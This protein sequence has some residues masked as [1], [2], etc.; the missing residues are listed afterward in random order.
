LHLQGPTQRKKHRTPG[1]SSIHGLII[2][3]GNVGEELGSYSAGDVFLS[4]DGGF[5]WE[6]IHKEPHIWEFGNSGSLLV[7]A[8][9]GRPTNHV[10]FSTDLGLTWAK[11]QFA[12]GE[13]LI[14]D[15]ITNP[16]GTSRRFIVLGKH[17]LHPSK[18]FAIK[19]DFSSLITRECMSLPAQDYTA[20]LTFNN[21]T[22]NSDRDFEFWSP[23]NHG[24]N[25]ILGKQVRL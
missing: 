2:G 25:C 1:A 13:L 11:H 21:I 8:H 16:S 23:Y 6:E 12:E 14:H 20:T 19:I 4:R 7:M 24:D 9:N 5:T 18:I 22:G 10:I 17:P 3:I 15:I